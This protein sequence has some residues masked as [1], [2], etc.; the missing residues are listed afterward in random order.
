MSLSLRNIG[1]TCWGQ[2]VCLWFALAGGAAEIPTIITLRTRTS[3]DAGPVSIGDV[4]VL[5]AGNPAQN[6]R[7]A[8][9]DLD[10]APQPGQKLTINAKQVEFRLLVAGVPQQ[11]FLVQPNS[12]VLVTRKTHNLTSERIVAAARQLIATRLPWKAAEYT[13][14]PAAPVRPI[15]G[16]IVPPDQVILRPVLQS[17]WPPGRNVHLTVKVLVQE[18]LFA[19]VPITMQLQRFS[20]TVIA[21]RAIK[22]GHVINPADLH[23]E[24]RDVTGETG[25]FT[26][27][28]H[29]LGQTMRV[30]VPALHII[31]ADNV[32]PKKT[33]Q[34][35]LIG[36]RDRVQIVAH[37]RG[38][39]ISTLGEAL[40]AGR[41]GEVIRVRNVN[42]KKVLQARVVSRQEVL[43]NTM[44]DGV[45]TSAPRV[46]VPQQPAAA[47][48]GP[49]SVAADVAS[50]PILRR[51]PP[52]ENKP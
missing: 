26:S 33:K 2:M 46:G 22:Q 5:Q 43:V 47:S 20:D 15:T 17:S 11:T 28:N 7:L 14:T 6:R 8:S 49:H 29:L 30:A 41:K 1:M 40:E 4:T 10:D 13:L 45:P 19:T 27:T 35:P 25:Y 23:V 3:V 31:R 21:L 37:T 36:V 39:R 18:Q 51:L 48:R 50:E 34:E 44:Y 16:L 32:I 24:R 12:T 52:L 9:I 42:S 38:L